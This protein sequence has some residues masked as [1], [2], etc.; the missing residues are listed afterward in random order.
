MFRLPP[1]IVVVVVWAAIYLPALGSFEIKGEEGRRI[2]PAIEMLESG[3]YLQPQI[4]SDTYFTK[5]PLVNWLVAVLLRLTGSRSEWTVRIPSALAVLVVAV[6]FITISR[7]G[8]G[9][10]GSVVAALVWLTTIG[11]IE[12]GRLIEIEAIYVSLCA[13]A[14]I[15]WM[16][17]WLTGRSPWLTW[18]VP[19]IWL[20]LGWLAKGPVHLL[21]FYAVVFAVLWQRK[22]LKALFHPA[23]LLGIVVMVGI[24]AA[25]AIP[26]VES[27]GQSR[28]LTKWSGQFT[29]RVTPHYFS[30]RSAASTLVRA[31]GQFL[32]WVIFIPFLRLR[33]FT[34]LTD[35]KFAKA[36]I[37]SAAA[38]LVLVSLMPVSAPRYSLPIA[39][40]FC[41]LLGL[42][43]TRNAFMPMSR[44]GSRQG[45]WWQRIGQWLVLIVAASCLIAFPIISRFAKTREKVKPI[46]A[47]IN[48]I[49]PPTETLYAV[50]PG[51]QPF[52]FY[53]RCPVRYVQSVDRIPSEA[54]YFVS[55]PEREDDSIRAQQ[56]LPRRATVVSRLTDYR[57]VQIILYKI[58]G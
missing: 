39:A 48:V 15:C 30:V 57:D 16:S 14:V 46:A 37:W 2:L 31:V 36:L 45:N 22:Q 32:P 21:F 9:P 8:L 20:G 6:A 51:Y 4:G 42:A 10:T 53:L 58:G 56:W 3:Q 23:H 26:F 34:E 7:A 17:W 49:V 24:F 40:P 19:W 54:H 52:L 44:F 38:P 47:Q 18:T 12:K 27:N 35:R 50:D 29:G 55:R 41:W 11:I 13:L 28:A 5:P 33:E 1:W 43:F 25:W